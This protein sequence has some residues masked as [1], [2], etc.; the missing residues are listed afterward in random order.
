VGVAGGGPKLWVRG[1]RM[2]LVGSTNRAGRRGGVS[3]LGAKMTLSIK[4]LALMKPEKI[5]TG[6][7]QRPT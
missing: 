2:S 6:S 5:L 1:W 3:R 7:R 4:C